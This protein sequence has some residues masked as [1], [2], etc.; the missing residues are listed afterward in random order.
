MNFQ[1]KFNVLP[2][3]TYIYIYI[4]IDKTVISY[5]SIFGRAFA[6]LFYQ[7]TVFRYRSII[8]CNIEEISTSAFDG[9]FE[10]GLFN[11]EL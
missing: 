2:S 1:L 5:L 10:N 9:A 8:N 11:G 6:A 3:F 7:Y 4:L